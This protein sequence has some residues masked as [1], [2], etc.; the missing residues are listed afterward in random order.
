PDDDLLASAIPIDA[1]DLEELEEVEEVDPAD[2]Q[3]LAPIE[4]DQTTG[5]E[6][7]ET[8]SGRTIQTFG[9]DIRHEDKWSRTPNTPGT[10]AIHVKTFVAKLR[11]DAIDHMDQQVNEWLDAHPQYEVKFVTTTVG[12][13]VGKNTED[14]LFMS[15][16][17]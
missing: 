13:L 7:G 10:G 12:K 6:S 14:A 4:I 8:S 2:E 5:D 11:L 15:V 1:A 9:P 16:W 17:V 3:D